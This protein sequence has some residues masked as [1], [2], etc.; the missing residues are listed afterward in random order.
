MRYLCNM[1]RHSCA[2]IFFT[3]IE[4]TCTDT[5][6]G[7]QGDGLVS[8]GRLQNKCQGR[9][10]YLEETWDSLLIM[11]S[12]RI[13]ST[14]HALL[15]KRSSHKSPDF[16]GTNTVIAMSLRRPEDDPSGPIDFPNR[17]D[18]ISFRPKQ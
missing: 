12:A 9:A 14:N 4:S 7:F 2:K 6:L 11:N 17:S 18:E 1:L 8:K 3:V 5:Q 15:P 16:S 10:W 13:P